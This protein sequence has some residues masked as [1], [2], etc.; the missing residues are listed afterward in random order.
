MMEAD[1]DIGVK[2]QT[3]LAASKLARH[4]KSEEKSLP[5]AEAEGK[6]SNDDKSAVKKDKGSS[7][8]NLVSQQHKTSGNKI[9]EVIIIEDDDEREK[10]AGEKPKQGEK[11]GENVPEEIMDSSRKANDKT[12]GKIAESQ[13][14]S[15]M[16]SEKEEKIKSNPVS[17]DKPPKSAEIVKP[18]PAAVAKALAIGKR[19]VSQADTNSEK[20]GK[21]K[22]N[23]I[24]SNNPPKSSEIV[25]PDP[26]AVAKALAI[27]KR[28][29]S[30]AGKSAELGDRRGLFPCKDKHGDKAKFSSTSTSG[31]DLDR[32]G[33][34]VQ[35]GT[36][37]PTTAAS[38]KSPSQVPNPFVTKSNEPTI[39]V[40]SVSKTGNAQSA[41][42]VPNP[43]ITGI[44]SEKNLVTNSEVG[45]SDV[46]SKPLSDVPNLG[47]SGEKGKVQPTSKES[48]TDEKIQ[49]KSSRFEQKKSDSG[50]QKIE[51]VKSSVATED[52]AKKRQGKSSR[53][54]P[55]K[56]EFEK[57][58]KIED[59]KPSAARGGP[60]EKIQTKLSRFEPMNSGSGKFQKMEDRKSPSVKAGPAVVRPST[61]GAASSSSSFTTKSQ[62]TDLRPGKPLRSRWNAPAEESKINRGAGRSRGRGRGGP[63]HFR[64]GNFDRRNPPFGLESLEPGCTPDFPIIGGQDVDLRQQPPPNFE[65]GFPENEPPRDGPNFGNWAPRDER[66]NW[67]DGEGGPRNRDR[68]RFNEER[69]RDEDIRSRHSGHGYEEHDHPKHRGR[70]Q[71]QSPFRNQDNRERDF[72]PRHDSRDRDFDNGRHNERGRDFDPG[73]HNQRDRNFDHG[74]HNERDRNFDQGRHEWDRNIDQ[75]R[76][77]DR[78]RNFDQGRHDDRDRNFDQ[79]R[80]DDRD[81][82]FDQGRHDERRD[83]GPRG[84]NRDRDI[85][86]RDRRG[87]RERDYDSGRGSRDRDFDRDRRRDSRGRDYSPRRDGPDRGFNPGQ[88]ETDTDMRER[89]HFD[90]RRRDGREA[91]MAPG[92]DFPREDIMLEEWQR[93]EILQI[94]VGGD[95]IYKDHFVYVTSQ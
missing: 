85:D 27:G 5:V 68:G 67:H 34:D 77:D 54:E 60:P 43:F 59:K 23:R 50:Q 36:L 25:K 30:Q 82:N 52:L 91:Q 22:S 84:D 44:V 56:S 83:F 41:T 65:P 11:G 53:F 16:N 73:R 71:E 47:R 45:K 9:D 1:G 32:K 58:T 63:G 19:I 14:V 89:G 49:V 17:S 39:N 6:H 64:G 48:H 62:D 21:T 88:V 18:D 8:K 46:K 79:G 87:S 29:V 35:E 90:D 81:R 95:M 55:V 7:D 93:D 4:A 69:F 12:K 72:L 38:A 76:H 40:S 3:S 33:S 80:H 86:R 61:S 70:S 13:L 51:A 78:D 20:E 42:Q 28:L 75:G 94:L 92:P 31:R 66:E 37:K 24:S 57:S 74:R 2:A 10:Y 26:E 15:D